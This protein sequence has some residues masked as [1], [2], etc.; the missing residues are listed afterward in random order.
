[1]IG[2]GWDDGVMIDDDD[3]DVSCGVV[4]VDTE[5]HIYS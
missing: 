2:V 5:H 3:V 1:M 4:V